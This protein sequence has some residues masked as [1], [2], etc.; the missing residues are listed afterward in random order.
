[1]NTGW[2]EI[3][4]HGCYSLVTVAFAPI[5]A[6]KN[7]RRIWR[8]NAS[9]SCSRDVTDHLWWRHHAKSEAIF[10]GDNGEMNDWWFLAEFCVQNIQQRV[11]NEKKNRF[12][13]M[14]N[15]F[16]DSWCD[17]PIIFIRDF[18]TLEN[19]WQITS[20]VPKIVI[21]GTTCI[22]L[23]ITY[24]CWVVWKKIT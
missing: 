12:V 18:V 16:C 9:T 1:M 13:T 8:H 15:D 7:N 11:T 3:D 20:L 21:H 23:Y 24:D 6:C 10:L 17:L 22:Y 5:G 14:N 2:W 19:H 4:I